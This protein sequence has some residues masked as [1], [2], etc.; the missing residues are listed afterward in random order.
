MVFLE[1]WFASNSEN[2]QQRVRPSFHAEEVPPGAFPLSP[3]QYGIWFA[4]Q[5]APEVPFCMAH[6]MELHGELDPE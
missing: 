3:A 5:L 1:K 2:P 4:Q 6:Y